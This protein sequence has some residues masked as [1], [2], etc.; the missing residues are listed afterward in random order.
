MPASAYS[1][2][3]L[4]LSTLRTAVS[5]RMMSRSTN[6]RLRKSG[7]GRQRCKHPRLA[8][9]LYLL[10][11]ELEGG[12]L[13]AKHP[14]TLLTRARIVLFGHPADRQRPEVLWILSNQH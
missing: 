11:D 10:E 8:K 7:S 14:R 4:P 3:N 9:P 6:M 5:K 13:K 12:S 2:D 1:W